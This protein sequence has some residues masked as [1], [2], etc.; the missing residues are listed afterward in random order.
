MESEFELLTAF[1][2]TNDFVHHA[3]G[4]AICGGPKASKSLN[5]VDGPM[6]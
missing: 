6:N 5:K 2:V 3:F 1:K 4:N